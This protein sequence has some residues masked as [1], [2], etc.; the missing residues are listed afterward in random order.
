MKK[1]E[2]GRC[3]QQL[4]SV[5]QTLKANWGISRNL[6]FLTEAEGTAVVTKRTPRP[7]D[8]SNRAESD[9]YPKT[10]LR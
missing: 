8:S 6:G 1:N 3:E 10:L 2:C 7:I 9:R 5:T 4:P